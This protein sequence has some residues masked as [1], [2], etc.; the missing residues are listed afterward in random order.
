MLQCK[1]SLFLELYAYPIEKLP[2][3]KI[4]IV[5]Q[6]LHAA[7]MMISSVSLALAQLLDIEVQFFF[8]VKVALH[9]LRDLKLPTL[10][11]SSLRNV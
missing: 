2:F 1:Y 7:E 11:N 8:L 6:R 4:G 5:F 3:M 9:L 10:D